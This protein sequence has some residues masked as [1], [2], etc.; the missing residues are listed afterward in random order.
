MGNKALIVV[1]YS[2]DFVADDGQLTAGKPAQDIEPFIVS[3]MKAYDEAEQDIFMMM[4]LHYENDTT[5]PEYNLFPP[6]NIANTP[7][8]ELYGK[9]K[10]TYEAI[11]DHEHVHFLD[12]TRYDS[13]HGTP[14]DAMLRARDIKNIEIVGV[15][16]DICVLHTAV[17]GYNLG[18]HMTIPKS[19]VA[20]FD[21]TGHDWA[22]T[23]FENSLGARVED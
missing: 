2:Y 20:S 21:Q 19:G 18:Y 4:D 7:G 23:H 9:V 5:H 16:T 14:L 12:K 3:R 17:G 8:R 22:L 6:H 10:D 13:F 1:D 15:C 11:Q